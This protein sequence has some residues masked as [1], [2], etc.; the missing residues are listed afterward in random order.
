MNV[1]DFDRTIYDGDCTVDFYF[2]CLRHYHKTRILLP[3]VIWFGML[4]CFKIIKKDEFKSKFFK[5]AT[6]IPDIDKAADKFWEERKNKIKDFYKKTKRP[7]DVIISASPQFVLNSICNTLGI[8]HLICT[9]VDMST[10]KIIGKNCFGEEKVDRFKKA[11]F[12]TGD[13]DEFYSDSLSDS[14]LAKISKK[15]YIVIKN[16][17][18]PWD[19]YR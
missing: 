12:N 14:P 9:N 6:L 10:G 13:V 5:F 19:K 3:G 1:Y 4:Y 2:Y 18:I 17:L 11:G 15:A 16:D 7:D 8:K